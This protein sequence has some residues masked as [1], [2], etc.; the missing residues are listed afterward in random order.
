M[1]DDLI[2]K[3]V[4]AFQN[5]TFP[6]DEQLTD[7][8]YGEEPDALVRDFAGK[9]DWQALDSKFLDQSPEGWGTALSFFSDRALQFYLPAFLIADLK[10]ELYTAD[11]TGRLCLSL[12][13]QSEKQKIA[14]VWGGGTIGEHA[15]ETFSLF[16]DDQVE[17]VVEYL[18]WRCGQK[19]SNLIIEHSLEHYWL[20]RLEDG[21]GKT[22]DHC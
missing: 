6:G 16:T 4:L 20:P 1:H 11:P 14:K 5:V 22:K 18:L 15:R 12:T 3:I 19:S 9:D 10:G 17:A 7:S 8:S 2:T 21:L 13:P